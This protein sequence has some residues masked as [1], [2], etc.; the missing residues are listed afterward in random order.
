MKVIVPDNLK[1]CDTH[2]CYKAQHSFIE[3]AFFVIF[4]GCV[5]HY[6]LRHYI[7]VFSIH[8]FYCAQVNS[9]FYESK[10]KIVS[11]VHSQEE[12]LKNSNVVGKTSEE[13]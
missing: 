12:T 6:P 3:Y 13:Q 5:E 1:S 8:T 4:L 11:S 2:L 10:L 9:Y 7:K